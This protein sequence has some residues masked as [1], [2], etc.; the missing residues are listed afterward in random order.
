V[1]AFQYLLWPQEPA[2]RL[3]VIVILLL[4]WLA[5]SQLYRASRAL[6]LDILHLSQLETGLH[7]GA[8]LD[9]VCAQLNAET[10]LGRLIRVLRG[11]SAQSR[12]IFQDLATSD[13]EDLEAQAQWPRFVA[14]SCVFI[15]LLGTI[16]G[17]GLA[18]GTLGTGSKD[19][20]SLQSELNR[21]LAGMSTG[22]SCTFY[23]VLTAIFIGWGVSAYQNA[24]DRFTTRKDRLF[25]TSVV[26]LVEAGVDSTPETFPAALDQA[27]SQLRS[28]LEPFCRSLADGGAKI[29]SAAESLGASTPALDKFQS[30]LSNIVSALGKWLPEM[31]Q[32]EADGREQVRQVAERLSEL[33]ERLDKNVPVMATQGTTI[34]ASIR[35][36]D[37]TFSGFI[38]RLDAQHSEEARM[39]S[40][41]AQVFETAVGQIQSAV[42][43]I[44]AVIQDDPAVH[45]VTQLAQQITGLCERLETASVLTGQE[46]DRVTGS[47]RQLA[48]RFDGFTEVL[49]EYLRE[50]AAAHT[51]ATEEL[52][53]TL[54]SLRT[55]VD[56]VE[57]SLHDA[58]IVRSE[59]H[60]VT[61]EGGEVLGA[62]QRAS[63]SLGQTA[64]GLHEISNKMAR[65]LLLLERSSASLS[66]TPRPERISPRE[67]P[68][69][70]GG[71]RK[72]G[73]WGPFSW[74]SRR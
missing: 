72:R 11:C 65:Q 74:W 61:L 7:R 19:P 45:K 20:A 33:A 44:E 25:T 12:A 59:L 64:T 56:L 49:R 14:G 27:A 10:R 42:Q 62:L 21:A 38:S 70:Q 26:P 60:R 1:S 37:K 53:T 34:A 8:T 73:R 41:Q 18:I 29:Q 23:G 43:M 55:L 32:A 71:T 31:A 58:P 52:R 69:T 48:S 40:E 30:S 57:G 28:S 3:V 35:E 66:A 15:G 22:F 16:L 68:Q 36:L 46:G 51:A 54:S 39:R 17:L 63:F 6:R 13:Q 4:S 47:L 5:L 2:A 9:D 24:A 50:E 67:A